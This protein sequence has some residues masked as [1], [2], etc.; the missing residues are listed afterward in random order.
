MPPPDPATMTSNSASNSGMATAIEAAV[1]TVPAAVEQQRI[2]L[3][4]CLQRGYACHHD[5]VVTGRVFEFHTRLDRGKR[6]RQCR[7]TVDARQPTQTAEPVG[8]TGGELCAHVLLVHREDVDTQAA[9]LA[10]Q[11][12]TGGGVRRA[13]RDIRRV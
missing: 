11:R 12:P 6:V 5:G 7:R 2:P 8:S 9:H 3:L 13:E 10:D 1:A 4:M